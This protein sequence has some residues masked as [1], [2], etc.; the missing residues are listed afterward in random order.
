MAAVYGGI[1]KGLVCLHVKACEEIYVI[2]KASVVASV[3]FNVIN[4]FM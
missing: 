2:A 4:Q 3:N 1:A